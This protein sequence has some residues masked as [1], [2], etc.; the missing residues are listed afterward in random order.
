MGNP[1]YAFAAEIGRWNPNVYFDISG[2]SLIKLQNNCE[3][4]KSIFWWSG[5]E[6]LHTP[7]SDTSAFE[8]LVFGS[9]V[10]DG[11]LPEFDRALDRY[12]RIFNLCAVPER[13]QE[14]IFAGTLWRVLHPPGDSQDRAGTVLRFPSAA[15][16]RFADRVKRSLA[17]DPALAYPTA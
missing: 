11:D 16:R 17:L 2:S 10:F 6:S 15:W 9:D 14:N 5:V 8:K 1:E 4:F 7:K 12:H 13:A 3:F